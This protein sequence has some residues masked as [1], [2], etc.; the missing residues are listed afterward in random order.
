MTAAPGGER[1]FTAFLVAGEES[2][3]LLGGGLM[4]ALAERLGGR[5]RFFGVGGKRMARLGL[6][7]LFPMEEI[8]HHGITAVVANAPRILRRIRETV[9][10][11]VRADPDVLVI[12]DCPGFNLVVARRVRRLRPSVTIVDYVSPSVWAY[13]PGRARAMAKFVDHILAILPFEPSVHRDLGGPDCSYV[14]HPLIER[15]DVLRPEPRERK[16]I[17]SVARPTLL[18]LPGSRRSEVARLMR[19][20]GETLALVTERH[21]PL[22]ILLP[23]VPHL[24]AE[25]RAGASDWPV[26]VR[27]VEGEEEKHAAFRRAHAALAASG[28]VT[29]ELALSGVPMVVAYRLDPVVRWFKWALRAKS[30]VLAN[31]VIGQNVIP[32]FID[33]ASS[34]ERLADALLPLLEESPERR[35]QLAAFE[36]IDMLMALPNATPSGRAAEIVLETVRARR[37]H[38]ALDRRG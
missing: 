34:P 4:Q 20:F 27:I 31:L 2:G 26:R 30:I 23:A 19:P 5:V 28:T 36:R 37:L 24:L 18:V 9:A 6:R 32:E 14:G 17:D 33:A 29:L 15:L 1:S 10:A 38:A 3:D 21:G 13:R 12:I 16:R 7:S 25:I 35:R 11:A 8:A 22:D